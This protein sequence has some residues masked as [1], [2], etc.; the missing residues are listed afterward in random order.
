MDILLTYDVETTTTA[1]AGRLRRVAKICEG[2]GHRVQKS[3]FEIVCDEATKLRL[4]VAL[5][6]VIDPQHDSIRLYHL[7]AR[8]LDE[9]EH[10]GRPRESAPR[11]PFVI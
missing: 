11:G 6:D 3:V 5:Q 1:G 2:Y 8:S 4:L 7:P 9:V 10:L